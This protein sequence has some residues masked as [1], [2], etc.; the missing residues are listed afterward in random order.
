MG[1]RLGIARPGQV[2]ELEAAWARLP[3]RGALAVLRATLHDMIAA[4]GGGS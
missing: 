2:V 1:R 4:G 3:R